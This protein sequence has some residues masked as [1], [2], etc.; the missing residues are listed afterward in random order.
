VTL[1]DMLYYLGVWS[2]IGC[3]IFSVFVIA[4][5][6]TGLVWTVRKKDG[7]L[8]KPMRLRGYFAMLI[9]PFGVV[10]LQIVANYLGLARKALEVSF[11]SLFLL[12]FG[13]DLIL[14]IYDTAVIDGLVLAM[15][16]P[17]FLRLPDAVGRESMKQHILLSIP[18]G[19]I[20]GAGLT[21]VSTVISYFTL[22]NR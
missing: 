15:W 17:R 20:V 4:V 9:I 12:N 13:Y 7:T 3:V 8:K 22:F 2:T 18:I 11:L 5:F 21:A 6:R 19:T 1:T 16:R 14:F 10:G